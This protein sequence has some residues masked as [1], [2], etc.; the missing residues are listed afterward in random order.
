MTFLSYSPNITP[1]R[2]NHMGCWVIIRSLSRVESGTKIKGVRRNSEWFIAPSYDNH[3]QYYR[4]DWPVTVVDKLCGFTHQGY[5]PTPRSLCV[6]S[7]LGPQFFIPY[8]THPLCHDFEFPSTQGV[9][10]ISLP[11]DYGF[12]HLTCFGQQG[13][14]ELRLWKFWA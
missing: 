6:K 7:S 14:T 9:E 12:S 2:N 11:F 13:D 10:C 1:C 5:S 8:C 4:T 3:H